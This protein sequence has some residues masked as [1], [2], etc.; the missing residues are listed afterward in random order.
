MESAFEALHQ[1]VP[2]VNF[3][4]WQDPQTLHKIIKA[5]PESGTTILL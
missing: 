2:R 4:Q 5:K 1:N 3:I